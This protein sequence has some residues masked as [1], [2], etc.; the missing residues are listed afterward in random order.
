MRVLLIDNY[1]SFT[2]NLVQLIHGVKDVTL[3]I[4][5]NSLSFTLDSFERY[6]CC[7]IS[8]GPG[9]PGND[10][11]FG[12]SSTAISDTDLPILGVC[13]G[14]QGLALEYGTSVSHAPEPWHGRVARVIHNGDELFNGVPTEFRAVRYHSLSVDRVSRHLQVTARSTDGEIMALRVR[15]KRRWGVQFHPE[16]IESEYGQQIIDNFIELCRPE[17]RSVAGPGKP[18][19]DDSRFTIESRKVKSDT[20]PQDLFE[21]WRRGKKSLV[22]LDSSRPSD[23]ARFSILV[24]TEGPRS[25][26]LTY[27]V[28]S[29]RVTKEMGGKQLHFDENIFEYLERAIR[30][31]ELACP[32]RLPFDFHLGYVGYLGYELKALTGGDKCHRSEFPDAQFIFADRAI[33]YDQ[34][35]GEYWLVTLQPLASTSTVGSEASDWFTQVEHLLDTAGS[36]KRD[37]G[38]SS[39]VANQCDHSEPY[40]DIEGIYFRDSYEE[41]VSKINRAMQKI[42]DGETYEVCLTNRLGFDQLSFEVAQYL[43]LRKTS[44][45]P[46]GAYAKF[47]K[48]NIL[49]ASPERFLKVSGMGDVE[50][51]PIKGTRPRA[52]DRDTDLA[53]R[54]ELRTSEK[55]RSENLMIVDLL[56]NDLNRSCKPTSVRVSKLFDVET[57]S[58]VH[59]LV[60]TVNGRL[61][62]SMSAVQCIKLAF[63]GGS[64]TGAPK[65]RTMQIIDDLEGEARGVYSGSIGYFSLNGSADF[66]IVIR[67]IVMSESKAS[68][69]I[70][71]AIIALSD[72]TDEFD[73][74]LV[75][76]RAPVEA[77]GV[78][79]SLLPEAAGIK[80][81]EEVLADEC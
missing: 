37:A 64:M 60:T 51:K 61:K 35:Q 4:I 20:S 52:E 57:Y 45:V 67:T 76:A 79:S 55:D 81:R 11:D 6:D 73:E 80:C 75:K 71:G 25:Y 39:S 7:I 58:H 19:G 63:P 32:K 69:G 22:W 26:S 62:E 74:T 59:Q 36:C 54:E 77:M 30:T 42:T 40:H 33:V 47:G 38:K 9:H 41:Y 53:V 43:K 49:C 5:E 13:L 72:A 24:D 48:L 65:I 29:N 8:P 10:D 12:I 15:G 78:K 31:T 70:G 28:N 34:L 21:I 16:S 68:I 14:H 23:E 50:A 1:D 44:P 46:Y 18:L 56:R 3:V 66:N 27:D 17:A 2:Y